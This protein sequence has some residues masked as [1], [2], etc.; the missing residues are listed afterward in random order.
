VVT[1]GGA[2]VVVVVL[3]V[4][5]VAATVMAEVGAGRRAKRPTLTVTAEA[6]ANRAQHTAAAR[7]MAL[8]RSNGASWF[9][10]DR[11][12]IAPPGAPSLA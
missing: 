10:R 1:R 12:P 9:R 7:T 3:V 2:V 6:M 4:G 11:R 8:R 5:N